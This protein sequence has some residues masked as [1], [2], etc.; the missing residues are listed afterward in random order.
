MTNK[1][2][3]KLKRAELL[4]LLIEQTEENERLT[5][6]ITQLEQKLSDRVITLENAGSIADA[7]VGLSDVFAQAQDAADR[8]LSSIRQRQAQA[9]EDLR[10]AQEQA[11]ALLRE[12]EQECAQ[13]R[14][15]AQAECDA[16]VRQARSQCD[17]LLAQA[18]GKEL[19]QTAPLPD[20]S[21]YQE[22][23]ARRGIL[24]RFR[25]KG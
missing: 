13:R 10:Q 16:L 15:Q 11:Q 20:L 25:N 8:Y 6:R 19:Q 21:Q 22:A 7:A 17:Q 1:D 4:E 14:S 9:E 18:R 12:A 3:R 23:S 2:A 24:S 5:Q